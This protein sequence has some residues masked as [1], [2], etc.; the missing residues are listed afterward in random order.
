KKGA[1]NFDAMAGYTYQYY[2]RN[3]R[4]LSA[5]NLPNDLIHVANVSGATLAANSNNT[6][7]N[8]ISYLGRLNYNYDNKY[9]F[10]FNIRRDGASR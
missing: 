6:E 7:W 3:Y 9:F 2:D 1:H 10:N 4:S 8:L 5:S